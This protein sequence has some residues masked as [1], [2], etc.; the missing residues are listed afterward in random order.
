M[1]IIRNET[2]FYERRNSTLCRGACNARDVDCT[3][4]LRHSVHASITTAITAAAATA[5]AEAVVAAMTVMS[6]C[7]HSTVSVYQREFS[8]SSDWRNVTATQKGT[9]E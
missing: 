4:M 7:K 6:V 3:T 5:A 1:R 8:R 9:S 2:S